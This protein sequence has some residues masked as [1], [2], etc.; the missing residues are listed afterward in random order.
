M[1]TM[2]WLLRSSCPALSTSLSLKMNLGGGAFRPFA[3]TT[4]AT[5]TTTT[6]GISTASNMLQ[7]MKEKEVPNRA[8][9]PLLLIGPPGGGKGTI[10]KML[11]KE[12]PAIIGP[13]ISAGD[14]LRAAL[15]L[16]ADRNSAA[17][18][19]MRNGGLLPAE[20]VHSIVLD[21]LNNNEQDVVDV[22][23][24]E[25]QATLPLLDGYPRTTEQ[26]E[27]LDRDGLEPIGAIFLDVPEDEIVERISSRLIHAPSGRTYNPF[28]NPPRVEGLDDETGEKLTR[29]ADDD[30][31]V[32]RNR[33]R[34]FHS[35]T[36]RPLWDY[37]LAKNTGKVKEDQQR[38]NNAVT[39]NNITSPC[40]V[41][42]GDSIAG[43]EELI[44]SG[45]RSEA[46]F[47]EIKGNEELMKI[48]TLGVDGRKKRPL[49][50]DEARRQR[51]IDIQSK[52]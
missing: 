24:Q 23:K 9:G 1:R 18:D 48:L 46:I 32:V 45:R 11:R 12:F 30:P 52:L 25:H 7:P 6:T 50:T 40:W 5:N 20:T 13:Y 21:R 8:G 47:Q 14:A 15:E 33:L 29:R 39:K 17:R 41:F 26:A 37:Y 3:T 2:K 42:S 44:S 10:A 51:T 34:L 22:A 38:R 43:G 27:F 49:L 19:V 31:T 16:D 35:Q 28:W 4:T 36:F